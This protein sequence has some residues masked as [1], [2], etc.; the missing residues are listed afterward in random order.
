MCA[1]NRES[2]ISISMTR[3]W[4]Y[5][6]YF[7][8]TH[9]GSHERAIFTMKALK[10]LDLKFGRYQQHSG[11]SSP[12]TWKREAKS[13]RRGR[14]GGR[15]VKKKRKQ[16]LI[17]AWPGWLWI[18]CSFRKLSCVLRRCWFISQYVYAARLC[19]GWLVIAGA[20][21]KKV[22]FVQAQRVLYTQQRFWRGKLDHM[23]RS[24]PET[25]HFHCVE[26]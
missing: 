24:M 7:Q 13:R 11:G 26:S 10:Y 5:Y 6:F 22:L 12:Y 23:A 3:Y 19:L 20:D 25:K 4:L 15:A 14:E 21:I 17:D 18:H 16:K 1:V 9:I 2:H 8:C